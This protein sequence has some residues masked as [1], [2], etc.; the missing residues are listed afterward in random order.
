MKRE[1]I[2]KTGDRLK[3]NEKKRTTTNKQREKGKIMTKKKKKL[4]NRLKRI[5]IYCSCVLWSV[6]I[7]FWFLCRDIIFVL[8]HFI[9]IRLKIEREKNVGDISIPVDL[10]SLQLELHLVNIRA[11][12]V[13][14]LEIFHW[15]VHQHQI[16]LSVVV[17]TKREEQNTLAR[18]KLNDGGKY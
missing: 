11:V 16:L 13:E 7:L 2:N 10:A 1:I 12:V 3:A 4:C 17:R 14:S 5:C 18:R 8:V 6:L 9:V 15:I